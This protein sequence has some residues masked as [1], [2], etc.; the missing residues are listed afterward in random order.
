MKLDEM[1][2]LTFKRV[3]RAKLI[4]PKF[5]S[6]KYSM[7]QKYKNAAFLTN[8]CSRSELSESHWFV[9]KWDPGDQRGQ[10]YHPVYLLPSTSE[11]QFLLEEEK[12]TLSYI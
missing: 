10:I 2:I 4:R 6:R 5:N 12:N 7:P 8:W 11:T 9:G 3:I 1:K